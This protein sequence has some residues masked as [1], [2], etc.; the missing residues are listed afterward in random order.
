MKNSGDNFAARSRLLFSTAGLIAL[1]LSIVFGLTNK[2]SASTPPSAQNSAAVVP[3]YEFDVATFNL[4]QRPEPG[5]VL[6]FLNEDSFRARNMNL[7]FVIRWAYGMWG[8][9]G[10]RVFGGPKWL[11]TE[12]YEIVAKMD[13]TVADAL[14][15]LSPDQRTLMQER[16]VQKLLADRLNL[17]IHRES[18]ESPVNALVIAKNGPKLH[19]A[20]PGDTYAHAFEGGPAKPGDIIGVIDA[21]SAGQSMTLSCFGVSMPALARRLSVQIGQSVEDKTG[22]TG[23]YDF[24]LK[25]WLVMRQVGAAPEAA[26]DAQPALSASDP[27]GGPSL[28]TAIQQQLGLKL[29]SVKGSVDFIVIDRVERPSGN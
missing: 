10:D 26:P 4:S 14:K 7:R 21:G 25:Y 3:T 23:S 19:E 9:G 8:G 1:A 5:G 13:P 22:L 6:G 11:D 18:K 12:R 29:D 2:T 24:T 17:A 15:K 20:V 27:A 28:F 16:M